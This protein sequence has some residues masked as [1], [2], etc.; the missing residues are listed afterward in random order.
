MYLGSLPDN[1]FVDYLDWLPEMFYWS[2]LEEV[3]SGPSEDYC[4]A[5]RDIYGNFPFTQP[6]LNVIDV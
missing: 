4:S 2:E 6:P 5:V 1:E 3:L